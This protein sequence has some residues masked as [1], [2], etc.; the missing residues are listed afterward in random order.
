MARDAP[1]RAAAGDAVGRLGEIVRES[2]LVEPGSRGVA[3]LSGGADSACLAAGLVMAVGAK[4]VTGLH[5]NYGLRTDS[6]QDQ[7]Q[8]IAQC[9]KL[10]VNPLI[11]V[12]NTFDRDL[13]GVTEG[14]LQAEAREY[15]Y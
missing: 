6:D 4:A 5:V 10:G 2:G 15:R 12:C 13:T 11:D 7:G 14:N 8:F 3:L 9:E 1:E